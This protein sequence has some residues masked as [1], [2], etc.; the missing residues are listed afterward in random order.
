MAKWTSVATQSELAETRKKCVNAEGAP[1]VVCHVNGETHAFQNACP[2]AGLPLGDG[3]LAGDIIVCPYHGY[4]YDVKSGKNA[5]FAEDVPLRKYPVRCV[6][7]KIEVDL[8][9]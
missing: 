8:E 7:D 3:E 5:D 9:G 2:H 6:D 1:I 4:A